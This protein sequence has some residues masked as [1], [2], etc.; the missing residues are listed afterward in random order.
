LS[1]PHALGYTLGVLWA[2]RDAPTCR[3]NRWQVLRLTWFTANA[4]GTIGAVH[5]MVRACPSG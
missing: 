3:V 4:A 2:C 1:L 5:I